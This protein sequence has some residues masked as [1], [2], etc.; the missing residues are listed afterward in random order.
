[1]ERLN[2]GSYERAQPPS[3]VHRSPIEAL[4][5][6]AEAQVEYPVSTPADLILLRGRTGLTLLWAEHDARASVGSEA[7]GS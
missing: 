6:V 7:A 5:S 4:L 3:V 1:M 2:C